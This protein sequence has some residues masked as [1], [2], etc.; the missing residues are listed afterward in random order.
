MREVTSH[1]SSA[2]DN[3]EDLGNGFSAKLEAVFE[4]EI[5]VDKLRGSTA[6][7]HGGG[8]NVAIEE[9]SEDNGCLGS[10][11][12]RVK[13]T[14]RNGVERSRRFQGRS[15]SLEAGEWHGSAENRVIIS[16]KERTVRC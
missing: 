10:Q 2:I 14:R 12:G 1:G 11:I 3:C 4:G 5:V 15:E 9:A 13:R 6:I 7:D 16:R 8:T